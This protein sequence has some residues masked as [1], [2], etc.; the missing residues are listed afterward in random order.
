MANIEGQTVKDKII[1]SADEFFRRFGFYKTTMDD[2]AHK[3]HKVKGVLY[4][5]FNSKEELY[6]EVI[7]RELNTVKDALRQIVNTNDDPVTML[8][9]YI[10]IRYRMLNNAHNYHET[11]KADF[12]EKYGF[13]EAVRSDFDQF[14]RAQFK[15]ILKQGKEKGYFDLSEI[16]LTIDV[17]MILSK[18]LEIP[19]YIQG[20][21]SEYEEII[22]EMIS[23]IFNGLKKNCD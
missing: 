15:K 22:N 11:L 20:K 12:R 8:E 21:Y 6:T 9:N 10:K 14:E 19:L 23:I 5:Y 16:D 13:V 3:I 17:I 1:E 4:Y 2:I 18:N 7:K